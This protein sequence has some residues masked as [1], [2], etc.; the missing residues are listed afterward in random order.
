MCACWP[1]LVHRGEI[2]GVHGLGITLGSGDV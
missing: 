2:P 1:S